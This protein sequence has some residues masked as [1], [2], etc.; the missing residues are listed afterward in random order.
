MRQDRCGESASHGQFRSSLSRAI[1]PSTSPEQYFPPWIAP[2][3]SSTT[4]GN[5]PA[6]P[7]PPTDP[8]T[9]HLCLYAV[10]YVAGLTALVG[11]LRNSWTVSDM[12]T[13]G[14]VVVRLLESGQH[15]SGGYLC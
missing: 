3:S 6:M 12:T 14:Y 8:A 13:T 2:I 15:C 11:L 10:C 4:H 9:A 1:P 5:A 7:A